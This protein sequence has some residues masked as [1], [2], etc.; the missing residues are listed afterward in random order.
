MEVCARSLLE[1]IRNPEDVRRLSPEQ[2]G[3]LARDL[4]DYLIE[5]I[6]QIGGHFASN[7]GNV[8]LTIALHYAYNSPLDAIVW[9]VSH[10]CYPHKL[11]TGRWEAFPTLRQHQGISGF[12]SPSESEHDLATTGHAGTGI[13]TAMGIA[14]ARRYQGH[15]GRVVTVVGDG[16]IPTGMS[17]E[18]L[19]NLASLDIDLTI[20][21]NDN[22]WSIDPTP[23]GLGRI[24]EESRRDPRKGR[25]FEDRGIRYLGPVDGHDLPLLLKV[26]EQVKSLSGP[27]LVHVV[28]VKG[29][30]YPPAEADPFRY[31][32][33]P[34]PRPSGWKKRQSFSGLFAATLA[35]L[36]AK[37]SRIVAISAGMEGGTGLKLF[38]EALGVSV[39]HVL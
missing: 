36:A 32:A 12:L 23:G 34:A 8:E 10:G 18:A 4:R 14:W 38:K 35:E 15:A 3:D 22:Q 37:D 27:V 26:F 39:S 6:P 1:G 7:L 19:N 13:S 24:L 30:G 20:V 17:Q 28:T 9:D 31:H 33:L 25:V 5:S 21:L 11:L 16:S 2:L 29:K